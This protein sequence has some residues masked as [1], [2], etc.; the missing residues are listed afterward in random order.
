MET[1]DVLLKADSVSVLLI[2]PWI[3]GPDVY[4]VDVSSRSGGF[5]VVDSIRSC[6][7]LEVIAGPHTPALIA[8]GSSGVRLEGAWSWDPAT[9]A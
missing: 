5:H 4:E 3:M 8:R 7:R 9:S 2:D 1:R 6:V